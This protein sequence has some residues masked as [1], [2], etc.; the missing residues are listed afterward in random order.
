MANVPSVIVKLVAADRADTRGAVR[1]VSAVVLQVTDSNVPRLESGWTKIALDAVTAEVL[2]VQ[3]PVEALVAQLNDPDGAA[4]QAATLGLAAVPA[5]AHLVVVA[6]RG[7]VTV[8]VNVGLAF[9]A[10]A[11]ASTPESVSVQVVEADVQVIKSPVVGTVA[12]P[13]IVFVVVAP[14]VKIVWA[15]DDPLAIVTDP[16]TL[17]SV[18]N[19]ADVP[20]K[21]SAYTV[22]VENSFTFP[23][24]SV[25][26]LQGAE[27]Q[28]VVLLLTIAVL[29]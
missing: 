28:L 13:A 10:R 22:P 8:P 14:L 18:P 11:V 3:V 17:L 9:G 19:V 4:E 5:A 25:E 27:W 21:I 23:R 24:A 16:A 15:F 29:G 1:P 12:N 26:M 20:L 7:R 6:S 2:T